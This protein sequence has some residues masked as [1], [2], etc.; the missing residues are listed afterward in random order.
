MM[1]LWRK[2]RSALA[3]YTHSRGGGKMFVWGLAK[4]GLLAA[5]M[6]PVSAQP[7]AGSDADF[8]WQQDVLGAPFESVTFEMPPDYEGE[9]F[10]TLVR[11]LVDPQETSSRAVLYVHGFNDYFFQEE[12]ASR[13]N[14]E[15]F[16]F[17]AVD[18][19]KYGRSHREHQK[20][21]NVRDLTEY[22]ADLDIALEVIRDAGAESIVLI[23]HSTGGLITT[24]YAADR[25][26]DH[27]NGM[28]FDALLLNSPFYEFNMGF[29]MR[30]VMLPLVSWRGAS[31][32]DAL[33][34]GGDD[35][36]SYYGRSIYAGQDGEWDFNRDWKTEGVPVTYGWVRA[37]HKGHQRVASGLRIDVPVLI[38]HSDKTVPDNVWA[39]EIFAGD[40][41][42]NVEHIVERG[43]K[44]SSP[45]LQFAEVRDGMHDLIL[46]RE[47]VRNEAY[48]IMFEWLK[49]ITEEN[50]SG[51][52]HSS[53]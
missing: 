37:I 41:V 36:V 13:F 10:V 30:N 31:R 6:A 32:P 51:I 28:P 44:I 12:K 1:F 7:V 23:G 22:Y 29:F 39:D 2:F 48:R 35:E 19:R 8:E 33:L 20:L 3:G 34:P 16:D 45:N 52:M 5:I 17:Y 4:L 50:E 25:P 26:A 14:D 21:T 53:N 24:L 15:G 11:R 9:V 40:A 47:P 49:N 38:M 42:L 46:S 27:E 43:K 18:L